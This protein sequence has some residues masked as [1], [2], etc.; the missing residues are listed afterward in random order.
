MPRVAARHRRGAQRARLLLPLLALAV[1]LVAS[2]PVQAAHD[3]QVSLSA[4]YVGAASRA[5]DWVPVTVTVT[6]GDSDFTGE[7]VLT[8]GQIGSGSG[9][10]ASGPG[11]VTQVFPGGMSTS[12]SASGGS[13]V[14]G[15]T[16][17]STGILV[18]TT[19]DT[20]TGAPITYRIPI[21]VAAG[22]MKHYSLTVQAA[23]ARVHA[24]LHSLGGALA[25]SGETTVPV[26][27]QRNPLVGVI[28]DSE[29]ALDSAGIIRLSASGT[30]LQLFHLAP[31]ALPP[32]GVALRNFAALIID[33][34]TTTALGS[35][36]RQALAD[37]VSDGGGLI[38]AT[39]AS[40]RGTLSGLP[41]ALIPASV[42]ASAQSR[43]LAS[44]GELTGAAAPATPV[45][46]STLTA[47]HGVVTLRDGTTALVVEGAHGRGRTVM[48]AFDPAIEP[49]ASWAGASSLVRSLVLRATQPQQ[50]A[51]A[52]ASTVACFKCPNNG[53]FGDQGARLTSALQDVPAFD[54]PSAAAFGTLVVLYIGVAG[55]LNY[56]VLQRL[57]RRDLMWLTVPLVSVA[58]AGATYATGL[59][60]R[61]S[62][63]VVSQVRV[64]SLTG[65]S[66][67]LV[68]T[69]ALVDTPRGGSYAV[70]QPHSSLVAGLVGIGD[71]GGGLLSA[72]PGPDPVVSL[73]NAGSSSVHGYRT[74]VY[75]DVTGSLSTHLHLDANGHLVGTV[76][77]HLGTD[78][79][80]LV[81]LGGGQTV[82]L[83]RLA[84]GAT[85]SVDILA[86]GGTAGLNGGPPP[87]G[88]CGPQSLNANRDERR[89]QE[90]LTELGDT[91][92]P[93]LV[94]VATGNVLPA[95]NGGNGVSIDSIDAVILPLAADSG[96]T[97]GGRVVE[98]TPGKTAGAF[99][100]ELGPGGAVTFE[101]ALGAHSTRTLRIDAHGS[102]QNPSNGPYGPPFGITPGGGPNSGTTAPAS[103]T[104]ALQVFNVRTHAWD[105]Q[106]GLGPGLAIPQSIAASADYVSSDGLVLIRVRNTGQ[107]GLFVIPP[108]VATDAT[109]ASA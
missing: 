66:R 9:S 62:G 95:E 16:G 14:F 92:G 47:G 30:P 106:P 15:G 85:A 81:A 89:R 11:C 69:F 67:A 26:L 51:V 91:A 35:D 2:P 108:S 74:S 93:E 5:G 10:Y 78:L 87:F 102:L 84:D 98:I 94:G 1:P 49:L 64:V 25:A 8:T 54:I 72:V 68:D 105:E 60:T 39:G 61:T 63:A 96:V 82:A 99:E 97:L 103:P 77:N 4:G 90:V 42:G 21:A 22:V 109:T 80:G 3:P 37:F 107:T 86:Q 20:G 71:S 83:G 23:E 56:V 100:S 70:P 31:S 73:Q 34:A 53:V 46:L 40:A 57:R 45:E 58:F 65:D 75:R 88:C 33:G 24:E 12:C 76:T 19:G 104:A 38:V 7:L 36:Q 28:S 29:T 50:A 43:R 32:T 18:R 41:A 48:T 27:S 17:S 6:G 79:A 13:A 59:G 55:P 101:Y 44:L 52:N